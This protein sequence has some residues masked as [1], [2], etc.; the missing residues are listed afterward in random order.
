[1]RHGTDTD[2]GRWREER[3]LPPIQ[4]PAEPAGSARRDPHCTV[5]SLPCLV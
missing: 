2:R 4:L 5:S 3:V 1:M